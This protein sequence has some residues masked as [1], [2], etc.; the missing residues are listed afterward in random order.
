MPYHFRSCILFHRVV[1]PSL[2]HVSFLHAFEDTSEP[3][4]LFFG[5]AQLVQNG[6]N[7]FDVRADDL[8]SLS[9]ALLLLARSVA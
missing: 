3:C 5:I 9:D 7:A 6:Q 1:A 8:V 2:T 4:D